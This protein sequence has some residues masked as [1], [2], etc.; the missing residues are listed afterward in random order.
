M[1]PS[2]REEI[3]WSSGVI[4]LLRWL[5]L[6]LDAILRHRHLRLT[7]MGAALILKPG[8]RMDGT[9]LT[10]LKEVERAHPQHRRCLFKCDCG[11]E[12]EKD[13]AWVKHLNTTSCGC[14]RKEFVAQ[15]NRTHSQAEQMTGCYRSWKAMKQRVKADPL[16][17]DRHICERWLHSFE[18]FYEDMGDRPEGYT[19]ER[20]NNNKGYSPDNCVWATMS[21]QAINK[22][23][24]NF[25]EIQGTTKSLSEWLALFNLSHTTYKDRI[26]A[27][28]SPQD[29]LLT[30]VNISKVA[31]ANMSTYP[32]RF[33]NNEFVKSL[34]G[35]MR[36]CFGSNLR[37]RHGK[38]AALT[39]AKYFQAEEG[40]GFGPMGQ[41]FAIPT[42]DEYLRSLSLS[43]IEGYIRQFV[44]YANTPTVEGMQDFYITSIG[45]GYAGYSDYDIAMLFKKYMKGN[46]IYRCVFPLPWLEIMELPNPVESFWTL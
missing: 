37:G 26:F 24:T 19:L 14:Y 17:K 36:F 1:S 13:L 18:N 41:S 30:P 6:F 29:A 42:K 22:S 33:H 34:P 20:K 32:L 40:N 16:Y 7:K 3:F 43:E 21:Q 27:G 38:G 5:F 35:R 25:I 9:R 2:S 31:P 11:K 12:V 46:W 45:T 10:F 4:S 15:K 39:A 23:T 44:E 28:M 8:D